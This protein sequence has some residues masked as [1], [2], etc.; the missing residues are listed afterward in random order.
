VKK[1]W[2]ILLSLV[3]VM[4]IGFGVLASQED[5]GSLHNDQTVGGEFDVKL[6]ILPY[7]EVTFPASFDFGDIDFSEGTYGGRSLYSEVGINIKANTDIYVL[8][9]SRGFENEDGEE[10]EILNNWIAYSSPFK[11]NYFTA[12]GSDD[13]MNYQ[14]VWDRGS[15]GVFNTN[16]QVRFNTSQAYGNKENVDEDNFYKVKAGEYTDVITVT[17]SAR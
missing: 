8:L 9:D 10:N 1:L 3:L 11:S 16:F 6:N 15:P 2:V 12:G 5:T 13:S 7:A 4:G 14:T 17:V